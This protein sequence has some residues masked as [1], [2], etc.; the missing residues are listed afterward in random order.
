VELQ[1]RVFSII[2][3]CVVG[4]TALSAVST[5]L[6]AEK[7]PMPWIYLGMALLAAATAI[8]GFLSTAIRRAR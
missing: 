8:P 6:L 7:V 3:L 1:G 4:G 5:G 2:Q